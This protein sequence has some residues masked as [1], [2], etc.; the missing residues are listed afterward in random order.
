[1]SDSCEEGPCE[2]R[3]DGDDDTNRSVISYFVEAQADPFETAFRPVFGACWQDHFRKPFLIV[4]DEWRQC[5][6]QRFGHEK[7]AEVE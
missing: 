4:T 1:M 6:F 5:D 3:G 2:S 7:I